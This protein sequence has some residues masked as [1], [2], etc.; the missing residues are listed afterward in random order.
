MLTEKNF[1]QTPIGKD[2]ALSFQEQW[3][4]ITAN[5]PSIESIFTPE[6]PLD[7]SM[8]VTREVLAYK[9]LVEL[10]LAYF[11]M[12]LPDV[13]EQDDRIII[14]AAQICALCRHKIIEDIYVAR[15]SSGSEKHK[16]KLNG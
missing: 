1:L 11:E 9:L 12:A 8:I 7:F 16:D 14:I 4:Y 3:D 2:D 13:Q 5:L 10:R 6:V 15:H